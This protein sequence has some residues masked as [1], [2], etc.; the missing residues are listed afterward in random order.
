[1]HSIANSR[2]VQILTDQD[3]KVVMGHR[4]DQTV[5]VLVQH[6]VDRAVQI[7]IAMELREFQDVKVYSR[8]QSRKRIQSFVH[9]QW[10]NAQCVQLAK[11]HHQQQLT[12]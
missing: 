2:D 11:E 3:V 4:V 5:M 10:E 6:R 12:L 9:V 7:L 8:L 1:M